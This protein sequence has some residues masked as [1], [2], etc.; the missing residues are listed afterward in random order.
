MKAKKIMGAGLALLGAGLAIFGSHKL[1]QEKKR[2]KQQEE[3]VAEVREI[4]SEQGQIETFYVQL[5]QSD[6]E[7]LVGGAILADGRHLLYR[8]EEGCLYY[9]EG[10]L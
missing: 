8:Y 9:E 10:E 4:L 7:K 6:A 2:L 5:Y 3:L 1:L